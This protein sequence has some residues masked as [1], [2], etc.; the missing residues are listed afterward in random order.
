LGVG[1][2]VEIDFGDWVLD[3]AD[4]LGGQII[5]KYQVGTN[6]YW[7]PATLTNVVNNKYRF[8][9]YNNVSTYSMSAGYPITIR[10]DNLNPNLYNGFMVTK[11]QWN[12]L[13]ITAHQSNSTVIEHQ[14]ASL[15]V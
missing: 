15:W 9:V 11:T 4:S 2:Y 3:Q 6:L 10:I 13:K 8:A 14:Y 1:Q 12:N 7:L 5:T